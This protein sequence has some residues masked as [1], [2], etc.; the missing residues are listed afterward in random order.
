[1]T[2]F[3]K[4]GDTNR[5]QENSDHVPYFFYLNKNDPTKANSAGPV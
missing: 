4:T 1:M 5:I 3:W 2:E